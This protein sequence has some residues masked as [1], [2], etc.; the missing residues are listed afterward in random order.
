[1]SST[2]AAVPPRQ[3]ADE[4]RSIV[5]GDAILSHPDELLVYECDAYTLEK[6]LP[7][8]VVMFD[9]QKQMHQHNIIGRYHLT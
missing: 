8:L 6:K 2:S 4:L 3:F 9:S 5:G 1:M 7:D